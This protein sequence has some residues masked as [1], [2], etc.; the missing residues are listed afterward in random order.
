MASRL[1]DL[2]RDGRILPIAAAA[3][4]ALTIATYVTV[5]VRQGTDSSD[6]AT[7]GFVIALLLIAL[8]GSVCAL[9]LA[10]PDA[11]GVAA[12]GASG[13]L[14]SLGVLGLFSIGLLLLIAGVLLVMW[15]KRTRA[16]RGGAYRATVAAFLI[17]AVLPWGLALV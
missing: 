16:Q 9:V 3:L 11:R 15:M 10:S 7:V 5:I 4:V 14:L 13:V 1:S 12:A 6:V 8:T 2:G 17:G